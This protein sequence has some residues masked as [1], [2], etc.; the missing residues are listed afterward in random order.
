MAVKSLGCFETGTGDILIEH[1]SIEDLTS[2]FGSDEY[3]KIAPLRKRSTITKS[4]IV[5]GCSL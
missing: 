1:P 4:I 3:K 5:E 2:C